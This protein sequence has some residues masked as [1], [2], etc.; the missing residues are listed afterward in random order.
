MNPEWIYIL[1]EADRDH[2]ARSIPDNL[3]LK[4]FPAKNRFLNK[5]LTYQ[6]CLKTAF[7][8]SLK[9][10]YVIYKTA[11]CAAHRVGGTE[12]N[13][14]PELLGYPE[15]IIDRV[16]NLRAGHLDSQLIHGILELDTV[17]SSLDRIHL[18]SYDLYTVFV[19]HSGFIQL[20]A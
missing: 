9:L 7:T 10:F 18:D 13:W 5:D 14:I 17:L 12:N 6:R 4:L 16:C 11:A 20:G 2:L 3:K 1:N 19:K 15:R 8:D